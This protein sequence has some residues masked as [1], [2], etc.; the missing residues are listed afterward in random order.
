MILCKNVTKNAWLQ[1]HLLSVIAYTIGNTTE[2]YILPSSNALVV[3]SSGV[4]QQKFAP[5]KS[6]FV[7][8]G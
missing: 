7:N 2:Q 4:W 8:S 5:T 6:S 1:I 3:I